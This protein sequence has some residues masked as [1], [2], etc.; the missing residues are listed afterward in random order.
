MIIYVQIHNKTQ[1]P[2]NHKNTPIT[3]IM[4]TTITAPSNAYRR[5][6]RHDDG[7]GISIKFPSDMMA[8]QLS[9]PTIH[10]YEAD[11]KRYAKFCR[12]NQIPP[13]NSTSFYR[14]TTHMAE[15]TTLSPRTINRRIAA[16]KTI[17][18]HAALS[19]HITPDIAGKIE[20]IPGVSERALRDR[21]KKNN[22]TK[23]EPGQMADILH[24]CQ[25]YDLRSLRDLAILKTLATSGIRR[26]ELLTIK[27]E[28][29]VKR[30]AGY[31]IRILG[32]TDIEPREAPLGK[33][34]HDA[35]I[36]WLNM[37]RVAGIDTHHIFT[38]FTTGTHQK[39]TDYPMSGSS[40]YRVVKFYANL[41]DIPNV[42]PHDFR[43]Y[44]GTELAEDDIK[45][46][47]EALG[48]KD[49][50]TTMKFY[51]L[52]QLRAGITDHLIDNEG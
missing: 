33:T 5:M 45:S 36:D 24:A 40:L 32:K 39:P 17:F 6:S 26:S 20:L 42:K 13:A 34:A 16:V 15:H 31:I 27:R 4:P 35:I 37:R 43:R 44:V 11:L 28:D 48:H 19:G 14:W 2:T 25:P 10:A 21:L 38:S 47:Q 1:T 51:V 23:I 49:P 46:A 52:K 12:Q 18:K 9:K 29:I 8:G 30:D 3:S 41:S 50:R 7:R 22:H